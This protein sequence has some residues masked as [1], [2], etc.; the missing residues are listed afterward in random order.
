MLRGYLNCF[1][2]IFDAGPAV[3]PMAC[4]DINGM[5]TNPSGMI[6]AGMSAVEGMGS[7]AC[8]EKILIFSATSLSHN[9]VA[10][11]VVLIKLKDTNNAHMDIFAIMFGAMGI[12]TETAI[13]RR[14]LEERRAVHPAALFPN[15]S[16]NSTVKRVLMASLALPLVH[17][18]T[19]AG[20][21][22]ATP[23]ARLRP[24][25]ASRCCSPACVLPA[26][27]ET[28]AVSPG[29]PY[30]LRAWDWG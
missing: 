3:L 25:K 21:G 9:K 5:S 12:N 14:C 19:A 26:S 23:A 27:E 16:D 1:G 30:G 13:V 6:Q 15:L 11:Q 8:C 18:P 22:L 2:K 4:L 20:P 17:V 7:I 29:P 24:Q 10:A 28:L